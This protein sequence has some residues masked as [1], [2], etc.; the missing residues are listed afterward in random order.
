MVFSE[1]KLE[2]YLNS[3]EDMAEYLNAVLET[4]DEILIQ[5][6]LGAVARARGMSAI[7]EDTGLSRESLYRALSSKGN[8]RVNTLTRVL[9]ALGLVLRVAPAG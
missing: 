3:P 5:D 9:G 6:A 2:D 7:A 4:E 1:W 8:P